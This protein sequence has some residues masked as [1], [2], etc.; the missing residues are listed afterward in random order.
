MTGIA[1]YFRETRP[2]FLPL[3]LVCFLL[4]VGTALWSGT[5]RLDGWYLA[6]ALLGGLAAHIAVN[7]LNDYIDHTSGLDH[8]TRRTPFSGGSGVL[9]GGHMSPRSALV[10][11]L[12]A[13]G[14][15]MGVGGYFVLVRGWAM[16]WT[17]LP[18]V[19]LIVLYTQ[20][21]TRSPW[22]CLVA[23]GLGF[24]SCMVL[25]THF[26][27]TGSYSLAAI[28]ASGVPFLLVST[29]LLL[30]QFPDVEADRV[31]GRC[32]LPIRW[33]RRRSARVYRLLVIGAFAWII[34]TVA[35]GLLPQTVLVALL[36]LPLAL[37][38]ARRTEQRAGDV[39]GLLPLMGYNVVLTLATPAL[40]AAGLALAVAF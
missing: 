10:F 23:P 26:V 33:G 3:T 2:H 16:L 20:W 14:V 13:L 27:L 25:G 12:S 40:M 31:V 19:L 21:L 29:L 28:A 1:I 15:T 36:P 22:L 24:G 32:H 9:T 38:T 8:I 4:G 17:G 6:L 39:P 11:G 30:N 34:V 7:V 18:G 37:L 5:G 35:F